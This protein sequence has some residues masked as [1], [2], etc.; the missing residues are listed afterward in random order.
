LQKANSFFP[1]V[2]IGGT[3]RLPF[4]V[5]NTGPISAEL[6]LDMSNYPNFSLTLP[7]EYEKERDGAQVVQIKTPNGGN[8]WHLSMKAG[9]TLYMNLVFQPT[10]LGKHSFELPLLLAG[11]ASK[12][13]LQRT[14]SASALK[15]PLS[16]SNMCVDF[17]SKLVLRDSGSK[18]SVHNSVILTNDCDRVLHWEI[19]LSHPYLQV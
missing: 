13:S 15:P 10:R 18:A 9:S 8:A 11:K 3:V 19:D 17:G 2:Y 5:K 1:E 14:I 6:E 7:A 4:T 12:S 16:I